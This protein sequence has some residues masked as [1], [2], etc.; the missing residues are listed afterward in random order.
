M[1]AF[2]KMLHVREKGVLESMHVL[3]ADSFS[4]PVLFLSS[5]GWLYFLISYSRVLSG[6]LC[7]QNRSMLGWVGTYMV[8]LILT[9]FLISWYLVSWWRDLCGHTSLVLED[10]VKCETE[11]EAQALWSPKSGFESQ[12]LHL[13]AVWLGASS[14]PFLNLYILV[15]KMG[16]IIVPTSK[17]QLWG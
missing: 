4:F 6:L 7:V 15:Q 10:L 17:N 9:D 2:G 3:Q 5:L 13:A 8:T 12:L 1:A 14:L 11:P 16:K